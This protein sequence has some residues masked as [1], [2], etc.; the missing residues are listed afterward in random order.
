MIPRYTIGMLLTLLAVVAVPFGANRMWAWALMAIVVGIML[1]AMALAGAVNPANLPV[2]WVRYRLPAIG[3]LAILAWTLVQASPL[4]PLFMHHPLWAEAASLLNRPLTGAISLDPSATLSAAARFTAY[5]GIFWLAMQ[6]AGRDGRARLILWTVFLAA[7]INAAYGLVVEFSGTST[8]LWFTKWAYRDVVTGTFVNRN[9]FGT[10]LG[11]AIIIGLA[12]LIE[13]LRRMSAGISLRTIE[14]LIRVSETVGPKFCCL[15]ASFGILCLAAILTG[16]RGALS[17]IAVGIAAFL[18]GA[19]GSSRV[20][21]DRVVR[22]GIVLAAAAMFG[23]ALSGGIVVNRLSYTN[24]SL[25]ER[26]T[27]FEAT[28]DAIAQHPL[29]GTGP[30]TFASVFLANRPESLGMSHVDYDHAHNTY[31]QVALE[32]GLPALVVLVLMAVYGILVF[33]RG[34]RTRR[35]NDLIPAIGIGATTL[36]AT[37]ALFDF[38]LEIPAVAATYLAIAGVSYAQSFNHADRTKPTG[39]LPQRRPALEDS[40][41]Q[42]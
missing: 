6:F 7:V 38:S 5:G 11:L 21:R 3:Y 25:Q 15:L 37:H 41:R 2:P 23:V 13:E 33:K 20:S 17:A 4:T 36:V 28:A 39:R 12:F 26:L 31:L 34:V 18:V 40:P 32:S 14:G 30:G 27:L 8:I 16:S 10:Y 1:I 19:A 42:P 9:H 22:L 35:H 24:A 29:T